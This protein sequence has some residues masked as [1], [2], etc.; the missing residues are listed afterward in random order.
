V[1][2]A[3]LALLVGT[4]LALGALAFVLYPIFADT[5]ARPVKPVLSSEPTDIERAVDA[6]REVEF[7]RATGKLSDTDFERLKA[8]Y[9]ADAVLAMRNEDASNAQGDAAEALIER[10]RR[11]VVNCPNCGARP[12]PAAAFCSNCGRPLA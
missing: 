11:A 12:E 7:D 6:L 9:T 8:A 10:Y 5:G 4:V 3:M 1:N 2:A